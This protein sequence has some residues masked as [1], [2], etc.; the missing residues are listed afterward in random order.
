M[1]K[2]LVSDEASMA[3][4]LKK[5]K[6]NAEEFRELLNSVSGSSHEN[7]DEYMKYLGEI[8]ARLVQNCQLLVESENG[9]FVAFR[10]VE[11]EAYLFAPPG[12]EDVFAH[13][14]PMQYTT[15]GAWYFH[16]KGN[17]YKG[18]TYKG[19]DLTFGSTANGGVSGGIL[20]RSIVNVSTLEIIEGP[21]RLVDHVLNLSGSSGIEEF[22]ENHL[23]SKLDAFSSSSKL[24]I[25]YADNPLVNCSIVACPR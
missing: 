6:L 22:V 16:K 2:R 24:K 12:F 4:P 10:F 13:R 20:L 5:C 1:S 19:L 18:G 25:S 11:V 17:S 7:Q 9:E 23:Q 3:E 21:C 15:C 8:C 14:D